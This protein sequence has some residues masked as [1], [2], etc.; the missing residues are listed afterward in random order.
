MPSFCPSRKRKA[1]LTALLFYVK[2]R[3]ILI[4]LCNFIGEDRMN[5]TWYWWCLSGY[6]S[7]A[8]LVFVVSCAWFMVVDSK[9]Q[10][11]FSTARPKIF[12]R[13]NIFPPLGLAVFWFPALCYWVYYRIKGYHL[14]MINSQDDSN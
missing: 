2:N 10:R 8:V 7:V 3:I 14:P 6:L 1:I 13:A 12:T 9:N 4:V 11:Q 5:M